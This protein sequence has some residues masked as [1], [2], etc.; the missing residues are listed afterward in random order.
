MNFNA[1]S[2]NLTMPALLITGTSSVMWLAMTQFGKIHQKLIKPFHHTCKAVIIYSDCSFKFIL[3][4]HSLG[5]EV[6]KIVKDLIVYIQVEIF[7]NLLVLF[8]TSAVVL[9]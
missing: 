4:L 2:T 1:A 9:F 6:I 3:A 8:S 5:S 7:Y